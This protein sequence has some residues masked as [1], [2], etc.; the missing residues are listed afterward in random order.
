L[1]CIDNAGYGGS[2][3]GVE[4]GGK[5]VEGRTDSSSRHYLSPNSLPAIF[6]ELLAMQQPAACVHAATC[7]NDDD[8]KNKKRQ[9]RPP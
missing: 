7:S 9:R 4:N 3:V 2:T 6:Q 1:H 8:D 5:A